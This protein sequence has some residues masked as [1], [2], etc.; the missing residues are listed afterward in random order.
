[1][2]TVQCRISVLRHGYVKKNHKH[3][4][5]SAHL[6]LAYSIHACTCNKIILYGKP[7]RLGSNTF[8]T[9]M[10]MVKYS[11]NIQKRYIRCDVSI[12]TPI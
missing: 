1:M 6:A 11:F 3:N 10:L 12:N 5:G 2:H 4:K 8:E 7:E 9:M